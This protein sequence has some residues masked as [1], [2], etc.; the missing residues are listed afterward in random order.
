MT[1]FKQGG[2]SAPTS[3]FVKTHCRTCAAGQT[4][5]RYGDRKATYCLLLR[6]WMTDKFGRDRISGCDRYEQ[7]EEE[8]PTLADVDS[9]Q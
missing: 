8:N 7:K 4:I 9:E 6:E 3:D 5:T 2:L 1:Y